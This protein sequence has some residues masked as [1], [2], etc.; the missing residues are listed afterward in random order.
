MEFQLIKVFLLYLLHLYS[1]SAWD[2]LLLKLS[3]EAVK[4]S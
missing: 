2:P 3:N 1:F 4:D